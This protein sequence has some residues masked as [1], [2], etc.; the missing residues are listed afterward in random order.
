MT[1]PLQIAEQ[2]NSVKREIHE[3]IENTLV[4]QILRLVGS[5][6]QAVTRQ[7]NPTPWYISSIFLEILAVTPQSIIALILKDRDQVIGSGLFWSTAALLVMLVVPMTYLT[8]IYILAIVREYIVDAIQESD[9][10]NKLRQFIF[11]IKNSRTT[12]FHA[13]IIS[14]V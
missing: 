3:I 10:L 6:I 4:A 9:D 13:L 7:S 14:L 5:F 8:S 1:K 2:R 12:L 11:Q